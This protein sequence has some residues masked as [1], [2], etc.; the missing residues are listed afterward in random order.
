MQHAQ[1]IQ[2]CGTSRSTSSIT[3]PLDG[4]IINFSGLGIESIQ[5][6][7]PEVKTLETVAMLGCEA[8]KRSLIKGKW[9]TE[10]VY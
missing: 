3:I 6:I 4:I 9:K 7:T 8:G 1:Q 5:I 2:G 10:G